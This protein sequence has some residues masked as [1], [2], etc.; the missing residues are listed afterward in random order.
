MP[1]R[2]AQ[3]AA[4]ISSLF[5]LI[6]IAV[7]QQAPNAGSIL[8]QLEPDTPSLPTPKVDSSQKKPPAPVP[9]GPSIHVRGF[10]VEGNRRVKTAR[11][12]QL[13]AAF[14]NRDLSPADLRQATDLIARYYNRAGWL[15]RVLVPPQRVENGILLIQVV[16]G[17]F[18]KVV[19][20]DGTKLDALHVTPQRIVDRVE[21]RLTPGAPLSTDDLTRGVLLAADLPGITVSADEISGEDPGLTNVLLKVQNQDLVN[22]QF[23]VDNYGQASIGSERATGWLDFNSLFGFGEEFEVLGILSPDLQFGRVSTQLPLND[24][25]L[26]LGLNAAGLNYAVVSPQYKYTKPIGSS[27]S[28]GSDLQ[29][30]LI[31]ATNHNLSIGLALARK[32]FY[33]DN[34]AGRVGDY[35]VYDAIAF[36]NG[37]LYD[38]FGGGAVSTMSVSAGRG[39]VSMAGSPGEIDDR[40]GPDTQGQF[41]LLR[42][43]VD[44]SQTIKGPFSGYLSLSG[45]LSYQN[46]D[47]SEQFYLGGPTGV[48][49]YPV[50]SNGGSTGQLLNAELRWAAFR[51]P[52]CSCGFKVLYDVGHIRQYANDDF[53][54]APLP[55]SY[56]LQ[57][58]GVG[59]YGT[60]PDRL[61]FAV[62][63]VRKVGG[64]ASAEIPDSGLTGAQQDTRVW[65]SLAWQF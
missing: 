62:T 11:I 52:R 9:A 48:R 56:F 14:V 58:V 53:P 51:S 45:Q 30:P 18:G 19:F 50:S 33:N 10:R 60:G 61:S 7:A 8:R 5:W 39:W 21:S 55:N 37:N 32:N 20:A 15:A 59:A 23:S 24:E 25:G 6:G 63:V 4:A 64:D 36:M 29:Y 35:H 22:G 31:R 12:Q 42:Y 16:E 34:I 49:A 47:P 54:F 57:G 2:L 38:R 3:C 65:A 46:L 26:V 44:R 41:N 17:R 27:D 43:R 40:F 28:W 1:K 13:L